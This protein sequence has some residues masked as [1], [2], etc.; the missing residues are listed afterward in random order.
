MLKSAVNNEELSEHEINKHS[1]KMT[2][3]ERRSFFL[4]FSFLSLCL[5]IQSF[6]NLILFCFS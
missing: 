4:V 1:D 6:S 5:R 3:H 2:G